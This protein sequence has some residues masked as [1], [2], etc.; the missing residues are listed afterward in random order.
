MDTAFGDLE[1]AVPPH[2]RARFDV[3]SGEGQRRLHGPFT[4][5][6]NTAALRNAAQTWCWEK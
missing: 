1:A 6:R 2:Y 5:L 3:I 4:M